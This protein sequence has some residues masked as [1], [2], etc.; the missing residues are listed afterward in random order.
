MV[1]R[2]R[3]RVVVVVT[4]QTKSNSQLV[5]APCLSTSVSYCAFSITTMKIQRL[6]LVKWLLRSMFGAL[7]AGRDATGGSSSNAETVTGKYER[8]R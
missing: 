2:G 5:P 7:S 6:V 3:L 1:F 8:P 4:M